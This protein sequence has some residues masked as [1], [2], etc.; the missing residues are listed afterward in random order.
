[1]Q[2]NAKNQHHWEQMVK[3]EYSGQSVIANWGNRRTYIVTDIEFNLSPVTMKFD[4]QGKEICVAEYFK[5]HYNMVV[6]NPKQPLFLI[7]NQEKN[8]YLPP[9]F[10]LIDGVSDE[11]KKGRGMR[12]ALA[13]TRIT[14]Q[15]K[16]KKIENM[17]KEL[18]N[19]KCIKDWGL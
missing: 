6:R 8:F 17:A 4:F 15:D 10:C 18:F 1:M 19:Q 7:K 5:S 3:L 11:V 12:D 9:E 13:Q 14:P 16:I 2:R